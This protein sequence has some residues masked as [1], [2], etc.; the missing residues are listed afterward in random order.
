MQKLSCLLP[1][2]MIVGIA[3]IIWI[4]AGDSSAPSQ[5]QVGPP[6]GKVAT[7]PEALVEG[8]SRQVDDKRV[9]HRHDCGDGCRGHVATEAATAGELV[10]IDAAWTD[11]A[12]G[13]VQ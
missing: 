13:V 3:V 7:M 12:G 11:G 5:E 8:P 10:E 6:A 1:A 9:E 2:T 4:M